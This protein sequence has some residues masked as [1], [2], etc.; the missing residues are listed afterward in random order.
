[1]SPTPPSL[2][3]QDSKKVEVNPPLKPGDK[4][5][6]IDVDEDSDQRREFMNGM[7][8]ITSERFPKLYHTYTVIDE[9]EEMKWST[10]G[11]GGGSP[12]WGWTRGYEGSGLDIDEGTQLL[13]LLMDKKDE[14]ELLR[15]TEGRRVGYKVIAPYFD[16]WVKVEEEVLQEHTEDK[17][18]P[19][20]NERR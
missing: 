20:V 14:D 10:E 12:R 19:Q 1:M 4:I 16:K 8:I 2:Q 17:V 9:N 11:R 5:K 13:W 3:E 7:D 18:N 15:Y 6:V